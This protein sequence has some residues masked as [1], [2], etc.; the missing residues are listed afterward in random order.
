MLPQVSLDICAQSTAT[1][2]GAIYKQVQSRP[3]ACAVSA[4]GHEFTY[5]WLGAFA[6]NVRRRLGRAAVKKGDAVA[7]CIPPSAQFVAAALGV[8]SARASYLPIDD[9]I[10]AERISFMVQDAEARLLIATSLLRPA[11]R[12]LISVPIIEADQIENPGW[13]ADLAVRESDPDDLAYIIYTSGSTGQ[14]KGVEITH[15]ALFNLVAWHNRAFHISSKDRATQ[16]AGLGFDAAVWEIWPYLAA[17]ATLYVPGDIVR[18]DPV[19]LQL[20]FV[21]ERITVAFAPTILAERLMQMEWPRK[22][23]LRLLLTGGDALRVYPHRGLPFSVVNNYG[24]TECT[25]VATSGSIDSK[26]G[27]FSPPPIGRPIPDTEIHIVD[28]KLKPVDSGQAGELCLG[29]PRLAR[30]YRNRPELTKQKFVANPF[31]TAPAARLYRTGDLVRMRADGQLEFVGRVDDQVKIR[32]YRIELNEVSIAISRHAA[33]AQC[34]VVARN[35]DDGDRVLVAYI[36]PSGV[37]PFREAIMREFLSKSL[38]D[39]MIPSAFVTLQEFPVTANGKIDYVA[40]P[41]PDRS[42]RQGLDPPASPSTELEQQIATV[43][44]DLLKLDEIGLEDNFFLLGGHSLFGAQLI[45][46]LEKRFKVGVPLRLLFESPTVASLAAEVS[47]IR[48]EQ[49]ASAVS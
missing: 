1:V 22:T 35:G 13:G 45:A 49:A 38:P 24:P 7:L 4:R 20:Y 6:E 26:D 32:G 48:C 23:A 46:R 5:S 42:N 33:V 43:V 31:Q 47:R 37:I 2:L 11:I 41:A 29:G 16:I 27:T 30:G 25:V 14:P 36:V 17:G 39:Y 28:E 3:K 19:Q 12:D 18:H 15:R 40:L 9:N 8:M 44:C 21:K 10:P 34:V